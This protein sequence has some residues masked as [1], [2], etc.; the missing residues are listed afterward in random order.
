VQ[1][2]E[3]PSDGPSNFAIKA[4]PSFGG[5]AAM[6]RRDLDQFARELMADDD[7]PSDLKALALRGVIAARAVLA[8][9]DEVAEA[10][11]SVDGGCPAN[12]A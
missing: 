9:F 12:E 8:E 7:L 1:L 3:A 10:A 5:K 11:L 2:S 4:A 6:N